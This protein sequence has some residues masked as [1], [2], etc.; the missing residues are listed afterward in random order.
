MTKSAPGL[1]LADALLN[2][3]KNDDA[4]KELDA[5][6][7]LEEK[8]QNRELQLRFSLEFARVLLAEPDLKASRTLLDTV[9]KEAEEGGF[10][11]LTWEAQM[12]LAKV[13]G[14]RWR[15][16]WCDTPA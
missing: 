2:L 11:S 6:R 5:L 15:R 9:A 12:V 14:E 10:A 4:K 13:Q 8:T 1:V 16:A 7:P 3:S